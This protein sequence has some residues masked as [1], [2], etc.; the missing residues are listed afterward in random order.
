[1]FL[2]R[3]RRESD[4]VVRDDVTRAANSVGAQVRKVERFRPH[5]LACKRRVAMHDAEYNFVQLFPRTI[6]VRS[7][8]AIARLLRAGAANG[9]RIDGL[10]MAGIRNKVDADLFATSGDVSA[11]SADVVFHVART[12]DAARI[13][14][15]K[16]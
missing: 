11:G 15:F 1:M 7:A 13:D 3:L 16:S 10:Q 2:S 6:N 5:A 9:N 12:Q 4:E 14:V 8:Q